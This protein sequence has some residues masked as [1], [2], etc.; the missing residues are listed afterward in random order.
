MASLSPEK[1]NQPR[2]RAVIS[3]PHIRQRPAMGPSEL[4][5]CDDRGQKHGVKH[6]MFDQTLERLVSLLKETQ[7]P[8]WILGSAAVYLKGYDPGD[9]GDIDVLL[10]EADAQRLI[11]DQGLDNLRD[12]GTDRY[13]SAYVLKPSLGELP[14]ELLAGY[15]IFHDKAWRSVSPLSRVSISYQGAALFVPSDQDLISIFTQ[16]GRSK[17]FDRIRAMQRR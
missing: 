13:R 5:F 4:A 14:V 10:S 2:Q 12:G 17:D 7:D 8:W 6:S 9:I 16:L 1:Q 11:S 15:E 3:L